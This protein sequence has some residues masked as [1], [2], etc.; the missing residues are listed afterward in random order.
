MKGELNLMTREEISLRVYARV[1]T[2]GFT[3]RRTSV[4]KIIDYLE[5]SCGLS[6]SDPDIREM[7]ANNFGTLRLGVNHLMEARSKVGTKVHLSFT[8]LADRLGGVEAQM[9]TVP[10]NVQLTIN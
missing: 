9:A 6:R 4:E 5:K 10:R 1:I 8:S 2:D 3:G 7:F